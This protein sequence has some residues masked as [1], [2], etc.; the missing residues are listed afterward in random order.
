M[1]VYSRLIPIFVVTGFLGS[2]KTT[3]LN[4]MLRHSSL[5]DAAV[6]INEF[7]A[8]G[9]DH[10]LV[11]KMDENTV[12]LSS[13]CLCCTIRDDLKSAILELN[14]RRERGEVPRYKRM[15]VETTGL[16]DPT[17]ILYTLMSDP[18]LRNHYRL[19]GV[20]T[21]VDAANGMRQLNRHVESVRQ[22][23]VADRIVITKSDLVSPSVLTGLEARLRRINPT[24]DYVRG[25]FGKVDVRRVLR[26]DV[27]DPSKKAADVKHW[28]DLEAVK[29]AHD[30]KHVHDVNRH[31][32]HIHSFVVTIDRPLDWTA[33]GVWL[34]MLLHRHGQ[35][36][37]RVKG[38]LNVKGVDAP[39]IINGVQ[40]IVHPPIHL[41]EWPD[42]D[43][44]S[45][46]V[47]IV[48]DMNGALI[49][50]S[51]AAFN[52]VGAAAA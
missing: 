14:S 25:N 44:R 2:G 42:D 35:Q 32:Q 8:V 52:R 37:L 12:L 3:L 26:A 1:A 38:I 34:T 20:I 7:G 9:L 49:E 36:V 31:D 24:A 43:R 39:V 10:F 51:L 23:T 15:V 19:G 41:A 27:Y 11:K 29:A 46:I 21:T 28:L 40:H 33:F 30:H 16:A 4:H 50:R 48:D 45:R 5:K 18:V 22:A 47:F 13:G 17:P 6:L